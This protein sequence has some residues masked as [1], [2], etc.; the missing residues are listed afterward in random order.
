M[1]TCKNRF[2]W[3]NLKKNIDE[4]T[5]INNFKG[6]NPYLDSFYFYISETPSDIYVNKSDNIYKY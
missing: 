1:L 4:P 3:R 6:N 5:S 2:K